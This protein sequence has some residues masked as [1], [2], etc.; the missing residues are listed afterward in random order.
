[1]SDQELEVAVSLKFLAGGR[2]EVGG[3][4]ELSS[5]SRTEEEDDERQTRSYCRSASGWQTGLANLQ[6]DSDLRLP[7]SCSAVKR[8]QEFRVLVK[9][10]EM[11]TEGR[12]NCRPELM[13]QIRSFALTNQMRHRFDFHLPC[14]LV[15][16]RG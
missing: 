13:M 1:M 11:G 4:S 9:D 2:G 6:Q 8:M 10:L 3:R 5:R 12:V 16:F 7:W 15:R 14:S